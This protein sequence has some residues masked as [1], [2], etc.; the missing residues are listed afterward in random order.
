MNE[1]QRIARELTY[2]KELL[3]IQAEIRNQSLNDVGR[4]LHDNIGQIASYVKMQVELQMRKLPEEHAQ[5]LEE[6]REQ[7]QNLIDQV[8]SLSRGLNS[9]NLERL[10]LPEM[11]RS[12]IERYSRLNGPQISAKEVNLPEF[13]ANENAIF[14]YRVFQEMINNAFKHSQATKIEVRWGF[15]NDALFVEVSDDGR[16]FNPNELHQGTGLM[17]LKDR[18]SLIGA[19][20][21]IAS[22]KGEGARF[23]IKL[24]V[25]IGGK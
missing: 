15:E 19:T 6:L 16:G 2:Q 25:Q 17:N 13:I 3:E 21:N 23:F 14:L 22:K 18:C 12:E 1:K 9:N 20:L 4:E 11:M 5:G 7:S 24:P 10:G 8:R